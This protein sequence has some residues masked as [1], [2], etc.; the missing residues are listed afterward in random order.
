MPKERERGGGLWPGGL[1]Q[2]CRLGRHVE[3]MTAAIE[4]LAW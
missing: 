2:G 1:W 4:T 3:L